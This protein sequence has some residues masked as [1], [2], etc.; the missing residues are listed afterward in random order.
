MCPR[1][2]LQ[3][4]PATLVLTSRLTFHDSAENLYSPCTPARIFFLMRLFAVVF[5]F[6]IS[7]FECINRRDIVCEGQERGTAAG[8][9]GELS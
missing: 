3:M 9:L 5:R 8:R 1:I 7:R 4:S 2:G 6:R